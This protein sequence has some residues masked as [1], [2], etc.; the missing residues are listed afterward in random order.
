MSKRGWVVLFVA[1]AM[2][3]GLP[4]RLA[5]PAEASPVRLDAPRS[6][7][8]GWVS[9][10]C[11]LFAKTGTRE[12][13]SCRV[14]WRASNAAADA[15]LVGDLADDL[16]GGDLVGD[17][18]CRTCVFV[19]ERLKRGTNRLLP[20]VCTEL[21]A[22][23]PSTYETCHQL[24][25]AISLNGNNVRYWLFEGCYRFEDDPDPLKPCPSQ[26]LCALLQPLADLQDCAPEPMPD[27]F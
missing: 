16:V 21:Y 13:R 17:S 9:D 10:P 24:L 20:T 26:L 2:T 5:A 14:D 18:S 11:S 15:S 23:Y 1:V 4:I 8:L 19:I 25:N 7:P 3:V 12:L 22:L 27:P 6:G